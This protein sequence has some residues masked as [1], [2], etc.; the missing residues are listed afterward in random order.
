MAALT[1]MTRNLYVGSAFVPIMAA[2]S[3]EEALR[4]VPEVYREIVDSG[5]ADRS[6]RLADE[7][8]QERPDVVGIQ[9]A[10]RLRA[11][12]V[13]A[14]PDR[15]VLDY[16]ALLR[17]AIER[18]GLEYR[19]VGEV[20]NIDAAMPSGYPPT[21]MLRLTD[22]DALL[23]AP[24]LSVVGDVETGTFEARADV[25][26]GG[27]SVPFARGW[28]GVR[29]DL[30]GREIPPVTTHLETS[31]FPEAQEAQAAEL[32]AWPLRTDLPTILIGDLNAQ[33]PEAPAYRAILEA[34]FLDAWTALHGNDPG[35]TCCQDPALRAAESK[36]Y[37][38]IDLIL[39]RGPWEVHRCERTGAEPD[40]RTPSGL[41]P[42]DHAGVV[43]TLDLR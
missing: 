10:V 12:P 39:F 17:V 9:E 1:V 18:R 5:F 14:E 11:G 29:N 13:D 32:L 27:G 16:L 6:E 2:A 26:V 20:W 24:G 33:A 8:A 37:E 15:D 23:T 35:L 25:E 28:I 4:A 36:L 21:E 7:I 22:R 38:R 42:S 40:A 30:E 3:L 43:A 34:G 19:S 41:W 31:Q